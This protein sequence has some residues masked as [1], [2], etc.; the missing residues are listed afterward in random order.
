M[1]ALAAELAAEARRRTEAE[2]I[3]EELTQYNTAVIEQAQVQCWPQSAPT[4][5]DDI[6]CL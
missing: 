4:L 1:D 6:L 3:A 2:A 5:H